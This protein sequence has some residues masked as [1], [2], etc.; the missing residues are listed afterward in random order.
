MTADWIQTVTCASKAVKGSGMRAYLL[1]L[2]LLAGLCTLPMAAQPSPNLQNH[3]VL[4]INSTPE[5][6]RN[7]EGA[8][9]NLKSGRILFLYSQFRGGAADESPSR[10]VSVYSDDAGLTWNQ[11]PELVVDTGTNQNVMSVS[12]LRLKSG[13]IALFY[14]IKQN[15]HDCHP[16]IQLSSDEAKTWSSPKLVVDAPG[17]FVLNNDRVIQLNNGRLIVP[18]AFHRSRNSKLNDYSTFDPRAIALWYLSDDEGQIWHEAETWWAMPLASKT[19]LQEPGVVERAD[20][21]VLSWARTDAG[22]QYGFASANSG[23]TWSAPIATEL[24]SPVSPASIKRLPGSA[25]LLA[26]FNDHSGQFP[27]PKGKRTP[28]VAAISPDGGRTWKKRKI[29]ENDPAG[30]YCYTAI[31]FTENAVLFA[32]L[33]FRTLAGGKST[34]Q[35]RIRRTTFDWLRQADK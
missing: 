3:V 6:P 10:I 1:S 26:V 30:S 32:Y 7:S 35:L 11:K 8:F 28:L 20:G 27:F 12:L 5:N 34:N 18:V 16:W 25:E 19:G 23:A 17:Y 9:L 33:D 14:L 4:D 24:K 22:A 29:L 31:H 2:L 21:T 15:L 13:K